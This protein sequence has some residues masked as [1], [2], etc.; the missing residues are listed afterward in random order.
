MDIL[1]LFH[2]MCSICDYVCGIV[3]LGSRIKAQHAALQKWISTFLT[4]KNENTSVG[5]STYLAA[6]NILPPPTLLTKLCGTPL[7]AFG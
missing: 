1:N 2:S 3:G 6:D 4:V 7:Y 5:C